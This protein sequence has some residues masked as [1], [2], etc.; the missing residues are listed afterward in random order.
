MFKYLEGLTFNYIF[1]W[2][3]GF[4]P[5]CRTCTKFRRSW[6]YLFVVFLFSVP[7]VAIYLILSEFLKAL[8]TVRMLEIEL[9]L[10]W[11]IS[12]VNYSNLG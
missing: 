7:N 6:G 8:S 1:E 11:L 9:W 2:V 5:F 10:L 4:Q 3:S 12:I